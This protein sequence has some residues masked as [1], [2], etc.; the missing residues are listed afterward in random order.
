MLSLAMM[1]AMIWSP[2][3]FSKFLRFAS[4]TRVTLS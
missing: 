4:V 2:V 1:F 3:Q